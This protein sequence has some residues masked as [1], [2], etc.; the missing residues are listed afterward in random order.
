MMSLKPGSQVASYSETNKA[1]GNLLDG[2]RGQSRGYIQEQPQSGGGNLT[3]DDADRTAVVNG[4]GYSLC[5][6][7]KTENEVPER[8]G[9]VWKG[10]F[11]CFWVSFLCDVCVCVFSVCSCSWSSTSSRRRSDGWGSCST[12]GTC[13]SGSWSWRLRTWKTL[14]THFKAGATVC[15]G[16]FK[17][18]TFLPRSWLTCYPSLSPFSL[19]RGDFPFFYFSGFTSNFRFCHSVHATECTY[20]SCTYT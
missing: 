7:P 12:R 13:T 1:M 8:L 11:L 9:I 14:T 6:P 4:D 2:H 15:L 16:F 20:S 18:T 10:S 19:H 3:A 5:S 17:P